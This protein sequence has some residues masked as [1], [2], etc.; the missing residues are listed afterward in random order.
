MEVKKCIE[1]EI[2]RR[3]KRMEII[4]R[5]VDGLNRFKRL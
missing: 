4:N 3:G 1:K 5:V 2:E